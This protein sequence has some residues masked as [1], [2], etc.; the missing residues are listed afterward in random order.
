M[1]IRGR[2]RARSAAS[3]PILPDQTQIARGQTAPLLFLRAMDDL[4]EA[5]WIETRAADERAIYVWLHH[6]R[7][8]VIRLYA[9]A[10]LNANLVGRGLVGDFSKRPADEH[11]RLLR[12]FRSC[13]PAGP[14]RPNRLVGNHGL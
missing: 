14:D 9:A 5:A 2:R 12:L 1:A 11:V 4:C 10:V 6:E 3:L 8:G 13:G 7:A